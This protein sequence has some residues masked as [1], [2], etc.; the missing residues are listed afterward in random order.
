MN[1]LLYLLFL[2]SALSISGCHETDYGQSKY[3]NANAST[4]PVYRTSSNISQ[5]NQTPINIKSSVDSRSKPNNPNQRGVIAVNNSPEPKLETGELQKLTTLV[6]DQQHQIDELVSII[7]RLQTDFNNLNESV[8]NKLNNQQRPTEPT[9]VLD[10]S[11]LIYDIPTN[12]EFNNPDYQIA[13]KTLS[14]GNLKDSETALKYIMNGLLKDLPT[15]TDQTIS[16]QTKNYIQNIRFLL[17]YIAYNQNNYQ[18]AI[19]SLFKNFEEDANDP[20][21]RQNLVLLSNALVKINKNESACKINEFLHNKFFN[22]E[23]YTLVESKLPVLECAKK[24]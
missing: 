10:T 12:T 1:Y 19:Q 21:S 23:D 15:Q 16:G 20:I 4:K 17:A 11:V 9:S 24:L 3:N 7:T 14:A 5:I 2:T 8:K 6:N 13:I 22:K 18:S